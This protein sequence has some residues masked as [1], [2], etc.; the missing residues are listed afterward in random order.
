MI[1]CAVMIIVASFVHK[2]G[3]LIVI[4]VISLHECQQH[5]CSHDQVYSDVV[6]CSYYLTLMHAASYIP[7]GK[8]IT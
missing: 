5:C 3:N 2:L 7:Q 1:L 6:V 8:Y 4:L